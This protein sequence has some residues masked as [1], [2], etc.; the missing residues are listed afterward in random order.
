MSAASQHKKAIRKA[1]GVNTAIGKAIA[2]MTPERAAKGA[3]NIAVHSKMLE[4]SEERQVDSHTVRFETL[5]ACF[6]FLSDSHREAVS[7]YQ[8]L[9]EAAT[10]AV[11][12]GY[13]PKADGGGAS[14]DPYDADAIDGLHAASKQL[15]K[16]ESI[17]IHKGLDSDPERVRRYILLSMVQMEEVEA[18][19]RKL[20]RFFGVD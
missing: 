7:R 14:G 8:D 18:G 5:P 1:G 19:A 6:G 16:S 10:P 11:T 9:R 2:A 12:G 15:T 20:A 13:A 17:I 4:G 3:Y